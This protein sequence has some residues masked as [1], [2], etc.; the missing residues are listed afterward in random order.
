MGV[1]K[2]SKLG[3][4]IICP[5]LNIYCSSICIGFVLVALIFPVTVQFSIRKDAQLNGLV[6]QG[7]SV[8]NGIDKLTE[9]RDA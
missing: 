3:S 8:P 2:L 4:F 1:Q 9:D 6:P 7:K 5:N